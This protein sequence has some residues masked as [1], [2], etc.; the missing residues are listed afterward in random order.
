MTEEKVPFYTNSSQLPVGHTDD[1]FEAVELQEKLQTKYTGGCIESGNF[2]MTDNGLLEIQNI[3]KSFKKL[4]P[5]KAIS[6][7][8]KRKISEWDLITDAMKVDVKMKDRIRIRAERGLDITT[9]NWHPFFVLKDGEV[10]EKRAD[11]LKL[12]DYLLQNSTF[13]GKRKIPL[14]NCQHRSHI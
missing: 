14:L 10:I 13:I 7:N 9:S 1:L 5:I 8:K 3:V 2:V 12:N 11:E 4:S 6:Y